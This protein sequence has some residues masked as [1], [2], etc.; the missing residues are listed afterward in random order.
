MDSAIG[1]DLGDERGPAGP[2]GRVRGGERSAGGGCHP[3]AAG[4]LGVDERGTGAVGERA[5]VLDPVPA[6]DPAGAAVA[7]GGGGAEPLGADDRGVEVA[8]G[9]GDADAVASEAAEV[10]ALAHRRRPQHRHLAEEEVGALAALDLVDGVEVVEVEHGDAHRG[11]VAARRGEEP[12][13][14]VAPGGVAG[15]AGDRVAEHRLL[16]AGEPADRDGVEPEPLHGAERRRP[17]AVAAARG[18]VD[19]RHHLAA[20]DQRDHRLGRDPGPAPPGDGAPAPEGEGGQ[21]GGTGDRPLRTGV[22]EAQPGLRVG[23]EDGDGVDP[24]DRGEHLGEGAQRRLEARRVRDLGGEPGEGV[25]PRHRPGELAGARRRTGGAG[26]SA[27]SVLRV[28]GGD[29]H[30]HDG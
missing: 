26:A 17:Q 16:A 10:V 12:G 8:A 29:V 28:G 4:D 30:C 18:E 9:E 25:E 23:L 22:D 15:E 7:G 14:D 20:V 2:S 19:E 24:G 3:R 11:P 1:E 6:G 13:E 27:P 5:P 21:A